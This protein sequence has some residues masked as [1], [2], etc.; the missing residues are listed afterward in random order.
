[1]YKTHSYNIQS[2]AVGAPDPYDDAASSV[3]ATERKLQHLQSKKDKMELEMHSKIE[4]DRGLVAY[5][6]G[7]GPSVVEATSVALAGSGGGKSDSSLVAARMKRMAD[8]RK[9]R[10]EGGFTTQAMR[11]LERMKKAKVL[12]LSC[13]ILPLYYET[14]LTKAIAH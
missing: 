3:S 14:P 7:N 13:T 10:E 4:T 12:L 8:E 2:A 6:A 9:K 11:D 1:M 5:R